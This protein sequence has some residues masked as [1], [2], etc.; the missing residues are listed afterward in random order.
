[1][2]KD[3]EVDPEVQEVIDDQKRWA[4]GRSRQQTKIRR[5]ANKVLA[6]IQRCDAR[7]LTIALRE[8]DVEEGSEPWKNAWKAF[9][10]QCH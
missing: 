6:A 5:L 3:D 1:M 2:A 4:T 9:H 8:A 10:D 7:A